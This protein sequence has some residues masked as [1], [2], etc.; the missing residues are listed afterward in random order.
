MLYREHFRTI[1][2]TLGHK[3]QELKLDISIYISSTLYLLS[4]KRASRL[5]VYLVSLWNCIIQLYLNFPSMVYGLCTSTFMD[6]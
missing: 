2:E 6:T 4:L 5:C 1:L 3:G